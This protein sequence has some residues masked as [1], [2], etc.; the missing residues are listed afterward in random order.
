MNTL[1][2]TFEKGVSVEGKGPNAPSY[3]TADKEVQLVIVDVR[4]DIH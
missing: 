1:N 2:K 3:C 4:R